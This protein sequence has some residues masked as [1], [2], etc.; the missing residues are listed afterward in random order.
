MSNVARVSSGM[1]GDEIKKIYEIRMTYMEVNFWD[2]D[3]TTRRFCWVNIFWYLILGYKDS[4]RGSSFCFFNLCIL[5]EVWAPWSS[6]KQLKKKQCQCFSLISCCCH[7]RLWQKQLKSEMV[8]FGSEFRCTLSPQRSQGIRNQRWMDGRMLAVC[9]SLSFHLY[10]LEFYKG[11][12]N[13]HSK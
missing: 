11:N 2:T 10:S 9:L 12:S 8:Y 1:S 3:L 5:S 4:P 6:E 13:T 7:K